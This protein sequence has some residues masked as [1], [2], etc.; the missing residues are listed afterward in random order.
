VILFSSF[1]D[2]FSLWNYLAVS[3][4]ILGIGTTACTVVESAVRR[5]KM[6]AVSKFQVPASD[7]MLPPLSPKWAQSWLYLTPRGSESLNFKGRNF[8]TQL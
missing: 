3:A 4:E 6:I 5:Q 2:L 7:T 8:A 1:G